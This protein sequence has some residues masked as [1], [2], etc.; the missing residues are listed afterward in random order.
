[1]RG[2]AFAFLALVTFDGCSAVDDFSKF[3]FADDGGS[4]DMAGGALPGFGEACTNECAPGQSAPT[5]PLMCYTMFGSRM[6]PGG[7]CTRSCIPGLAISCTDYGDA[8]CAHVEGM[9]VCLRG[10]NPTMGHN[11]RTGYDC[12]ANMT[13]TT[14]PGACAPTGTDFCG[15]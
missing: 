8:V 9:D 14:G 12:C 3:K 1:M 6:V 7:D 4:T 5:R 13:S 11:C 15:H 10:C 2:L